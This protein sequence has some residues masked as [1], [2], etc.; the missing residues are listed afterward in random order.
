[1]NQE[2]LPHQP[3]TTYNSDEISISDVLGKLFTKSGIIVSVLLLVGI[4]TGSTLLLA[5]LTIPKTQELTQP[6]ELSF[7]TSMQGSYPN[8]QPFHYSN[9]ADLSI[10]TEVYDNS[11]ISNYLTLQQFNQAIIVTEMNDGVELARMEFVSQLSKKGLTVT[12]QAEIEANYKKR[13]SSLKQP[14][15]KLRWFGEGLP[16]IPRSIVEKTLTDILSTWAND[17][18]ERKGAFRLTGGLLSPSI[19]ETAVFSNQEDALM[20]IDA[21]KQILDKAQA[22][23]S[24]IKNMPGALQTRLPNGMSLEEITMQLQGIESF[25]FPMLTEYARFFNDKNNGKTNQFYAETRLESLRLDEKLLTD[26][27]TVLQ[28]AWDRQNLMTTAAT[29]Q[30]LPT[31]TPSSTQLHPQSIYTLGSSID[32]AM[33][34]KITALVQEVGQTQYRQA[35]LDK[36]IQHGYNVAELKKEMLFYK[37]YASKKG[38]IFVDDASNETEETKSHFNAQMSATSRTIASL[39]E[40]MQDIHEELSAVQLNRSGALYSLSGP[41]SYEISTMLS[42]KKMI[43]SFITIIVLALGGTALTILLK[44]TK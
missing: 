17:A 18:I 43:L 1:M 20:R 16:E 13:M 39:L 25:R 32:G 8:G 27:G 40:N 2:S 44:P 41:V 12:E 11:E 5:R 10:L 28:E 19:L 15:F 33:M 24:H 9:I 35:L 4:I 34:D 26:Q 31:T 21:Y 23:L 36:M 6:F 7:G 22:Q 14:A 38:S 42:T 3:A 30:Q 37:Q 29:A